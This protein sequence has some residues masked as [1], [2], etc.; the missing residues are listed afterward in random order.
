[1]FIFV[2]LFFL[3]LLLFLLSLLSFSP[4][5]SLSVTI[6]IFIWPIRLLGWRDWDWLNTKGAGCSPFL[7]CFTGCYWRARGGYL[8]IDS[9]GGGCCGFWCRQWGPQNALGGAKDPITSFLDMDLLLLWDLSLDLFEVVALCEYD[10]LELKGLFS[11]LLSSS[12]AS[13]FILSKWKG[14]IHLLQGLHVADSLVWPFLYVC[15]PLTIITVTSI[16]MVSSGRAHQK[17]PNRKLQVGFSSQA[18]VYKNIYAG[19]IQ[20]LLEDHWEPMWTNWSLILIWCERVM[21]LSSSYV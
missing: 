16:S 8:G 10:W 14:F 21:V 19:F 18:I 6:P 13:I 12:N 20:F 7:A 9:H 1:M 2:L 3:L 15:M 11:S 5:F 17:N 4:S